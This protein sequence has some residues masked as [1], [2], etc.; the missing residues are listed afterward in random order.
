MEA[1][2]NHDIQYDIDDRPSV[3]TVADSL[4]ANEK[5]LGEAIHVFEDI[6]SSVKVGKVDITVRRI[7]QESPL[8]ELLVA[9]IVLTHQKELVEAV[10]SLMTDLTGVVI[11]EKYHVLFTVLVMII[12]IYGISKTI[13]LLFPGRKKQQLDGDFDRLTLVAGDLIQ[14]PQKHIEAVVKKRYEGNKTQKI[15]SP[16]RQFFAPVIGKLGARVIGGSAAEISAAAVSEI[17]SETMPAISD[18]TEDQTRSE[19]KR[20]VRVIIHAMDR[21]RG[22]FGWAGHI[23]GVFEDRVKMK[24][25]KSINPESLFGETEI[26][27]DVLVEYKSEGGVE[28]PVG[29]TL[30]SRGG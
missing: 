13:D 20:G 27:G 2:F 17:P 1:S 25:D 22:K 16:A 7:V 15:L 21:D 18:E 23:P 29:M 24:I 8:R 5:L 11:P 28:S 30:L 19:L 3:K 14:V 6:V 10:P 4:L 12:A 26:V 9:T